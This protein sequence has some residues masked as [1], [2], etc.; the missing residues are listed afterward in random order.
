MRARHVQKYVI[1][2]QKIV[3]EN[4]KWRNVK[5]YAELVLIPVA[6]VLM[7]AEL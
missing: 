7:N 5:A 6:S 4:L 2:V 1:N 3:T